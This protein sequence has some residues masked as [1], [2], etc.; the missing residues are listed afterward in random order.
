MCRRNLGPML[1]FKI[2]I[3]FSFLPVYF[4]RYCDNVVLVELDFFFFITVRRKCSLL[5]IECRSTFH[6]FYKVSSC[7][8]GYSLS[9]SLS[10]FLCYECAISLQGIAAKPTIMLTTENIV[11]YFTINNLNSTAP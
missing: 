10:M 8:C 2:F 7:I 5:F 4:S 9:L 1:L 11:T 3:G 6:L